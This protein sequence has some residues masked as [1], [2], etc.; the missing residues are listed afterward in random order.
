MKKR[1][2]GT[3]RFPFAVESC[4]LNRSALPYFAIAVSLA[5]GSGLSTRTAVPILSA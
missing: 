5:A 3:S 1:G 4:V 2:T